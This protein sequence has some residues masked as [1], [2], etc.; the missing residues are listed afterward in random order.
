MQVNGERLEKLSDASAV[1][2]KTMHKSRDVVQPA[3]VTMEASGRI[4]ARLIHHMYSMDTVLLYTPALQ[5]MCGAQYCEYVKVGVR[6]YKVTKGQKLRRPWRSLVRQRG[7][8]AQPWPW[9]P[10]VVIVVMM[11][12]TAVISRSTHLGCS[13]QQVGGKNIVHIVCHN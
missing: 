5:P 1:S 3:P 8:P 12:S 4:D 13:Q 6:R 10:Q 9:H 7:L 2:Y 11:H